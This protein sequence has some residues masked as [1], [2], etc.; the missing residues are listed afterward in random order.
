MNEID[1]NFYETGVAKV[2]VV[3]DLPMQI[4]FFILNYA[5]LQML[6]FYHDFLDVFIPR[7]KGTRDN[8]YG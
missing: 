4:G 6:S 2:K 5:N 7:S 1:E 3:M 8:G